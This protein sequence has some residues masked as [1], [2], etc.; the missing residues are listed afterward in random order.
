MVLSAHG[1][2]V[3]EARLR[4]MS[5]CTPL[6]TGALQLIDAARQLG[7]TAG[8]KYTLST[9]NELA[10]LTEAGAC[11]IVYVDLW[12]LKG[13]LS[14]QFH[15]LV[16]LAVEPETVV[17]LDPLEGERR[18]HREAFMRAWGE[19]RFLTIVISD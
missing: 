6:G 4:Q 5:D 15:A 17:V 2:D 18:I 16:V 7:F 1:V 3:D 13:G 14:G 10:G 8:R 11:P 9:L 12:P 19:M